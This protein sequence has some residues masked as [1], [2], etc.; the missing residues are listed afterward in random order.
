MNNNKCDIIIVTYNSGADIVRCLDS[1]IGFSQLYIGKIIIIDNASIDDTRSII[2]DYYSEKTRIE[3]IFNDSNAGFGCAN[4]QG[5]SIAGSEYVLFLNPDTAF[6]MDVVGNLL[7]RMSA[8]KSVGAIGPALL[9]PDGTFQTGYGKKPTLTTIIIEFIKS[10][11]RWIFIEF[12][13]GKKDYDIDWVS[14]GCLLARTALIKSI[15][16]FDNKIFM[17]AEDVDLCLR[18]KERGFKVLY[19]PDQEIVHFGGSSQRQNRENSLIANMQS[20]MY[21]LQKYYNVKKAKQLKLFFV[22]FSFTK[23][24]IAYLICLFL[25]KDC[26]IARAYKGA[27]L[28]LLGKITCRGA[29]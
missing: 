10:G 6:K 19:E 26:S 2:S 21:Y 12:I 23:M 4:N 7:E 13:R 1:V 17:Y 5:L 22:F 20:R 29:Q 27:L 18:I 3:F 8:N 24:I 25:A 28:F 16:G 14:G 11:K 15:G 9:R